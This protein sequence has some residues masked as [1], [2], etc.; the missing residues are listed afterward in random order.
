MPL[1]KTFHQMVDDAKTR[2]ENLS[3]EQVK[4]ELAAG[5]VL[6]V[7]IRDIR[8]RWQLGQIPGSVHAA[9]GMLEAWA[10]PDSPYYRDFFKPE[11]RTVLY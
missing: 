8:E 6:L 7:D 2:I 11:R 9:R 4:Q 3:I 5:D 1:K 10:D